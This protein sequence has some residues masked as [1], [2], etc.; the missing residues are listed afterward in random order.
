MSQKDVLIGGNF[1]AIIRLAAILSFATEEISVKLG[2]TVG[3]LV[4]A[5]FGNAVELIVSPPA[6]VASWRPFFAPADFGD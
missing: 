6:L 5:T 4:N 3:G 1:L 2:E